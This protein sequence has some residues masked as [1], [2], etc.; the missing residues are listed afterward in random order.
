MPLP[1]AQA[2]RRWLDPKPAPTLEPVISIH[3]DDW[4][5]RN[6][7]P[8]SALG[9]VRADVAAADAASKANFDGVGWTAMHAIKE[10][11]RTFADDGLAVAAVAAVLEPLLPR[12]KR[13][14]AGLPGS[15]EPGETDPFASYEKEAWCYGFDRD[16][17]LKVDAKDD[18][19][20]AI[21]FE[22]DTADE[23]QLNTL[24]KA[25]QMID[26]VAPCCIAD[27]WTHAVGSVSDEDFLDRYFDFL[28]SNNAAG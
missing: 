12:V 1:F 11:D 22:A 10:P 25:F 4:G 3:E 15:M 26:T 9:H 18:L 6:L 28:A 19:V 20:R 2:L 14:N 23:E 27:Y 8:V 21:W 5:M 16:C 7:Y 24:F 13:F 17:F